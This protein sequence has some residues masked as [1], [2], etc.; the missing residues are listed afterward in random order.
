MGLR[1]F[2]KKKPPEDAAGQRTAIL[3]LGMHRSG[4]SALARTVNLLGATAP[5]TLMP[6][7]QTNPR[8][9]W[10]SNRL[11]PIDEAILTAFG[12]AWDGWQAGDPAWLG[13]RDVPVLMARLR[14]TLLEEFADAKLFVVKDPRLCRLLPIWL[15]VLRSTNVAAVALHIL[16][17]IHI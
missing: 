11:V 15:E 7:D 16:S 9:F 12:S 3:V 1:Y 2:V 13:Y 14:A 6:A 8:G 10:E 4:T 5:R 17:L